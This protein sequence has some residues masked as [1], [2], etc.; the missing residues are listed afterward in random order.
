MLVSMTLL[1]YHPG[2]GTYFDADDSVFIVNTLQLSEDDRKALG[3]GD[4][5]VLDDAVNNG[6][7]K[8]FSVNDMTYGN[9]ISY[10]PSSIRLE[11]R[12]SLKYKMD[13]SY[14]EMLD[15]AENGASDDDL[16]AVAEYVL[17][18]DD[19][20]V[21]FHENLIDGLRWGH[22]EWKQGNL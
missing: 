20:W 16:N 15:W 8:R 2:T 1:I 4:E 14:K 10:S 9:V 21:A 22:D 19:I 6:N 7:G 11:V 13:E 5:S 17:S 18:S 12:E 3:D